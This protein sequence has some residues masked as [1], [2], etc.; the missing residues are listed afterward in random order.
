MIC[1]I[2]CYCYCV[3]EGSAS[4][5][6]TASSC[7]KLGAS[8]M[9]ANMLQL[10]VNTPTPS[11]MSSIQ[12]TPRGFPYSG[13]SRGMQMDPGR[14]WEQGGGG[15]AESAGAGISRDRW[16]SPYPVLPGVSGRPPTNADTS[17]CMV[18]GQNAN[19]TSVRNTL[20]PSTA[21][22]DEFNMNLSVSYN[23]SPNQ[24]R[25]GVKRPL[26][27]ST[28]S[29]EWD[30]NSII[31]NSPSRLAPFSVN[32]RGSPTSAS[33]T[34]KECPGL[35]PLGS[36]GHLG[37]HMYQAA[38]SQE[39]TLAPASTMHEM[40]MHQHMTYG[41]PTANQSQPFSNGMNQNEHHIMAQ[42]G[43]HGASA[44]NVSHFANNMGHH[45][46]GHHHFRNHVH[47]HNMVP[48]MYMGKVDH[49][50]M[51]V[52]YA[53]NHLE[54]GMAD[55]T[56]QQHSLQANSNL[57]VQSQDSMNMFNEA[58]ICDP[59]QHQHNDMHDRMMHEQHRVPPVYHH[60]INPLPPN[61]PEQEESNDCLGGTLDSS[62]I[63]QEFSIETEGKSLCQWTG[64][65]M[66]FDEQN[67][68]VTHIEKQHIDQRRGE[69]FTCYWNGC[70][71]RQKPFNARYKLLIH[72]R[73]HS[74]ERPNKCPVSKISVGLLPLFS[75]Y[76]S[77]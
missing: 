24:S 34:S 36:L 33:T 9:S 28:Q 57:V 17:S 3:T 58:Y 11:E 6:Q 41:R 7:Q 64:C 18:P 77:I 4:H 42:R 54:T 22:I 44:Q 8:L 20:S 75:K 23:N 67:D 59:M 2:L 39:S 27:N 71:R 1:A 31:R 70:Q 38:Q 15:G 16:S 43:H 13:M 37:A 14:A 47:H 26:S 40:H 19:M 32:S 74:G 63:K 48:H 55:M 35:V 68:L 25:K 49:S 46:N 65:N 62:E 73:V 61:F 51:S 76:F 12:N 21:I 52:H 45:Q 10:G 66:V 29:S 56:G 50:N 5:S 30:I 69:D 60:V 53:M 72:M